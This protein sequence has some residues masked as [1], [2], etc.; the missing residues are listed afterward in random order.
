MAGHS[1]PSYKVLWPVT[2]HMGRD[3]SGMMYSL[4]AL[5]LNFIRIVKLSLFRHPKKVFARLE[6]IFLPIVRLQN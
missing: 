4:M 3:V 5:I 2:G 1:L 6:Q